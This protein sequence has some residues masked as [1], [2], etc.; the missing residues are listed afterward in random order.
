[1][2]ATRIVADATSDARAA[3]RRKIALD[4]A[5]QRVG[6]GPADARVLNI[7]AGGFMAVTAADLPPGARVWLM[8]PGRRRA[9]AIVVWAA[10]GRVGAEFV[11][12]VD[13]LAIF[14][15]AGSRRV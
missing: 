1:M 12:E 15:A 9:R 7:S 3:A 11:E 13:V 10:D 2:I 5:V 6:A 8:L 4:T 14:T